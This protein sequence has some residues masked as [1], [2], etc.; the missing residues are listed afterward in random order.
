MSPLAYQKPTIPF[1]YTPE[2]S[3][4]YSVW[5]APKAIGVCNPWLN[6]PAAFPAGCAEGLVDVI[7][8]FCFTRL[9]DRSWRK[10]SNH[11]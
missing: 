2:A 6:P 10:A 3:H 1:L 11:H 5:L 9:H 7:G 8:S 4:I